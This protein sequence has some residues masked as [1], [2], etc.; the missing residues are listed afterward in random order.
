MG[1]TLPATQRSTGGVKTCG[2]DCRRHS[3]EGLPGNSALPESRREKTSCRE[4]S[5]RALLHSQSYHSFVRFKLR[6]MPLLFSLSLTAL[7]SSGSMI[8]KMIRMRH[9][10]RLLERASPSNFR[11]RFE[12][13]EICLL[14]GPR[15]KNGW[16]GKRVGS[17]PEEISVEKG[18]LASEEGSRRGD[19]PGAFLRPDRRY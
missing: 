5:R 10:L 19:W 18:S 12:Q 14:G 9:S 15:F 8:D 17:G 1:R 13:P 11:F 16:V 6:Q 4:V 7:G 2:W 3:V